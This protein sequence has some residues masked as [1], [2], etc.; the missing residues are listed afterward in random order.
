MLCC[1]LVRDSFVRIFLGLDRDL[2]TTRGRA[3]FLTSL[4]FFS[5]SLLYSIP[6]TSTFHIMRFLSKIFKLLCVS[7]PSPTGNVELVEKNRRVTRTLPVSTPDFAQC[8]KTTDTSSPETSKTH[9]APVTCS[10]V[11]T[12]QLKPR[13]PLGESCNDEILDQGCTAQADTCS[14]TGSLALSELSLGYDADVSSLSESEEEHRDTVSFQAPSSIRPI[15]VRADTPI[16]TDLENEFQ[17]RRHLTGRQQFQLGSLNRNLQNRRDLRSVRTSEVGHQPIANER[18][19]TINARPRRNNRTRRSDDLTWKA[20]RKS[21][22]RVLASDMRLAYTF[23]AAPR[24]KECRPRLPALPAEILDRIIQ[25]V[26]AFANDTAVPDVGSPTWRATLG[27]LAR[28]DRV[29]LTSHFFSVYQLLIP[30]RSDTLKSHPCFTKEQTLGGWLDP[31][32]GKVRS[33]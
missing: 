28:V 17:H 1:L 23:A 2:F 19:L 18:S 12:G 20:M 21:F 5:P 8:N 11:P 22:D 3:T 24:R 25:H 33:S 10:L 30:L 29:S 16:P 26:G 27:S 9:P 14:T 6:L 7:D 13:A 15:L 31:R 32:Y 4:Y